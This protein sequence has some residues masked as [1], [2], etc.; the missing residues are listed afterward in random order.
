MKEIKALENLEHKIGILQCFLDSNLTEKTF[1][2]EIAI[3]VS[4][5]YNKFNY[6]VCEASG[7]EAV[8]IK[9]SVARMVE[10]TA[11]QPAWHQRSCSGDDIFDDDMSEFDCSLS[12][13][14]W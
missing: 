5:L 2:K 6:A 10:A 11:G 14:D 7:P 1:S 12:E 9:E 3:L 13:D 8:R 4:E